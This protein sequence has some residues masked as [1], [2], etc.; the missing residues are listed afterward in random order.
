MIIFEA[1]TYLGQNLLFFTCYIIII[2]FMPGSFIEVPVAFVI[3]KA[4]ESRINL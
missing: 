3:L 4:L 1:G 2:S